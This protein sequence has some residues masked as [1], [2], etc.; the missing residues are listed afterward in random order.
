[1]SAAPN[2][3]NAE[4]TAAIVDAEGKTRAAVLAW[5]RVQR[6]EAAIAGDDAF[7]PTERELAREGVT[8]AERSLALLRQVDRYS[9]EER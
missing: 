7:S 3:K 9:E 4:V 1:M 8:L 6:A 2:P 5:E